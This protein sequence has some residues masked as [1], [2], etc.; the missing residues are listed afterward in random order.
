MYPLYNT[1]H[2][3]TISDT[4][5]PVFARLLPDTIQVLKNGDAFAG[6][7]CD[8][9]IRGTSG[10]VSDSLLSILLAS[11]L[12]KARLEV[13]HAPK[14]SSIDSASP[15]TTLLLEQTDSRS[16][17]LQLR[18]PVSPTPASPI[19]ADLHSSLLTAVAALEG[20]LLATNSDDAVAQVATEVAG[21]QHAKMSLSALTA[22]HAPPKP[23]GEPLLKIPSFRRVAAAD[24][25]FIAA[26]GFAVACQAAAVRKDAFL[27]R[28][29]RLDEERRRRQHER[30]I[31][32]NAV[33]RHIHVPV[34]PSKAAAL[35]D[36]S[37]SEE[38]PDAE[39]K[40]NQAVSDD[41]NVRA[42]DNGEQVGSTASRELPNVPTAECDRD[43][44]S[45]EQIC[46]Q[47]TSAAPNNPVGEDVTTKL[48]SGEP[49]SSTVDRSKAT[50]DAEA[51]AGSQDVSTAKTGDETDSKRMKPKKKKRK[52]ARLV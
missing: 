33:D 28:Q 20:V 41:Q 2:R 4:S 37:S 17:T 24:D 26:R 15:T 18:I 14:D 3:L 6:R 13:R 5:T 1:F 35:F 7:T 9:K 38:M 29:A 36:D 42:T 21:S 10:P 51:L 25:A 52:V 32:R 40:G 23:T 16:L 39:T 30:R 22:L 47:K 27:R 44:N 11:P 45:N 8:K 31:A 12:T 48:Q 50:V 46:K 49:K 19:L 43:A 34:A